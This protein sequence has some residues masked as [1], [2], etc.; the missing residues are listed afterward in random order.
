MADRR[1]DDGRREPRLLSARVVSEDGSRVYPI[2]GR[3]AS[4]FFEYEGRCSESPR[5]WSRSLKGALPNRGL[6]R[7]RA[8]LDLPDG[9][10]SLFLDD[11]CLEVSSKILANLTNG[12][13]TKKVSTD[14]TRGLEDGRLE[15]RWTWLPYWLAAGPALHAEIE[16]LMR[17]AVILNGMPLTEDSL[18]KI[19]S[20]VIRLI[21]RRFRIDG[22]AQ[23]LG[24]LKHVRET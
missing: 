17:D 23:Y 19:D 21:N 18:D 15:L 14:E 6:P 2:I 24:A 22:L 7:P 9:F 10:S 8:G 4:Y 3:S 11:R 20:F 1:P 12:S 5:A 13:R 16:A